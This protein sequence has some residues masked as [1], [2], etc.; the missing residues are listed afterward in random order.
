MTAPCTRHYRLTFAL[1]ASCLLHALPFL[2]ACLPNFRN[3]PLPQKQPA[4]PQTL[5]VR[6]LPSDL[7]I[8]SPPT[9]LSPAPAKP[10]PRTL[11]P[12]RKES[13]SWQSELKRQMQA[14][15]AEGLFYSPEAIRQGLQGEATV[16]FLLDET[17]RVA[18]ARIEISSG[19]A[20]LDRDA[21]SAV[22]RLR[23]LPADAPREILLPVRFRLQH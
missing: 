4:P 9:P 11:S 19:H 20:L 6:L 8:V 12:A 7:K 17:G 23:A 13:V 5:A 22:R 15:Q 2:P 16:F 3:P 1:A 14:Q 21:L 10:A 18:A